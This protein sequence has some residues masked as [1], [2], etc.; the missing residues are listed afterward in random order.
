MNFSLQQKV[1]ILTIL[2]G[3]IS[4][5]IVNFFNNKN[6][7]ELIRREMMTVDNE[8]MMLDENIERLDN[9]NIVM[10]GVMYDAYNNIQEG[11]LVDQIKNAFNPA[12]IQRGLNQA[13]EDLEKPFRVLKETLLKP[14]MD[15]I[16]A[17]ERVKTFFE[18]VKQGFE[19]FG[20][21]VEKEF[22]NL[23]KSLKLGFSDV[24]NVVGAFGW[25][26]ITTITN[27]RSCILWYILDLIATTLYNIIVRLPVFTVRMVTGF[28]LQPFV[29]IIHCYL[30]YIDSIFL[31]LTCYHIFHF[32]KWVMELCYTC[33]YEK[34][35][36][37][38]NYDWKVKIPALL[39]EPARLFEESGNHF[40][41]AFGIK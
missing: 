21:G 27:I 16:N 34:R 11:N 35:V 20:K 13:K 32:Q 12:T 29:D 40:K 26:G 18:D 5:F 31:E 6:K 23:G 24:F 8:N 37:N 4:F 9:G 25:C 14:I 30:E 17:I 1:I 19:K 39:N 2:V 36:T 28:N 41:R 3:L 7:A 38:L 22:E 33:Q 15:I 10:D